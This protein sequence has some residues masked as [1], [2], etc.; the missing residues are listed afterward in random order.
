MT[1]GI[2]GGM[3]DY[4]HQSLSDIII[5]LNNEIRIINSFLAV[6]NKNIDDLKIASYW[7]KK[8]PYDFRNIVY[9][10]LRHYNTAIAEFKDIIPDLNREVKDHHIRRLKQIANVAQQINIDIGQIWHKEYENKE[11]GNDDFFKVELVY[12]NTRDTAVSL[13]D[14]DNIA[15]RLND[16]IGR[17]SPQSRKNNPWIS[18]SFYLF[19]T[20]TILAGLSLMAELVSWY[21]LPVIIISGILIISITGILQLRNDDKLTDKSFIFLLIETYKRLPLIRKSI[22]D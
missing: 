8:V 9:Y 1:K 3:T 4:S 12:G 13:L 19:S 21:I 2:F 17:A 20:L 14:I 7:D 16:F 6:I 10:A 18:G 15:E 11:Y 5:D 22:R